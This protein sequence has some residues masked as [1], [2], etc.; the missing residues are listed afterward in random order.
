MMITNNSLKLKSKNIGTWGIK[1]WLS[2]M[3]DNENMWIMVIIFL[4]VLFYLAQYSS[5]S[6][7]FFYYKTKQKNMITTLFFIQ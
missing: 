3:K 2:S 5:I 1:K 6:V 7:T 4:L